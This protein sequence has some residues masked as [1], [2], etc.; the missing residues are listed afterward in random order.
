MPPQPLL[1][2]IVPHDA[3]ASTL[4]RTPLWVAK[5]ASSGF[6]VRVCSDTAGAHVQVH[7]ARALAVPSVAVLG[8]NLN[9]NM[10][11]ARY[12]QAVCPGTGIVMLMPGRGDAATIQALNSGAD[13]CCPAGVSVPLLAAVVFG[14]LRRLAAGPGTATA[15]TAVEGVWTLDEGGSVLMAP[16]GGRI[17]L[18]TGER[19]FMTT[20]LSAPGSKAPHRQLIDAVNACYAH[21]AP[22]THQ[23][24]LG[25][26][27]SRLRRKFARHGYDMPLKSVHNWGYM[28]TGKLASDTAGSDH[29]ARQVP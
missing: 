27:I 25:V 2:F 26:L 6:Q 17:S 29:A 12:L 19:A 8:G 24:R 20:L 16:A 14:L 11:A 7:R 15:V 5:L 9:Q 3:A 22:R 4:R 21:A 10:D 1:L 28:F 23:A 18:T 13:A